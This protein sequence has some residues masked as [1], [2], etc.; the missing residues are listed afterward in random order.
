MNWA[1]LIQ[2]TTTTA[3]ELRVLL[4]NFSGGTPRG[5]EG[6]EDKRQATTAVLMFPSQER[7]KEKLDTQSTALVCNRCNVVATFFRE[8]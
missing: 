8:Y 6:E 3:V 4:F 5:R 7:Q 2:C 1:H